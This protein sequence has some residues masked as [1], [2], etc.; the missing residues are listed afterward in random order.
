[1][2]TD[3]HVERWLQWPVWRCQLVSAMVWLK[4]PW[5]GQSKGKCVLIIKC[6]RD[7]AWLDLVCDI[8]WPA[9][10]LTNKTKFQKYLVQVRTGE[11]MHTPKFHLLLIGLRSNLL[12]EYY[13][14]QENSNSDF[15]GFWSSSL[16][17]LLHPKKSQKLFP[18]LGFLY[19]L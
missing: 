8:G 9:S 5:F 18:P 11:R 3:L 6:V 19:S 13:M 15:Q 17:S 12:F 10:L 1:M 7:S 16:W 4:E 14:W 2:R